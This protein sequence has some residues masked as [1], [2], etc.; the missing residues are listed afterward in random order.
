MQE[1]LEQGEAVE[2]SKEMEKEVKELSNER[3]WR[4]G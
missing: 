2:T 3:E 1:V 4:N